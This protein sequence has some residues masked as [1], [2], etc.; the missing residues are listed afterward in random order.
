MNKNLTEETLK[1]FS[2]KN[3]ENIVNKLKHK[4]EEIGDESVISVV[5]KNNVTIDAIQEVQM[6]IDN[7]NTTNDLTRVYDFY[8]KCS[9]DNNKK[10]YLCNLIPLKNLIPSQEMVNDIL[11]LNFSNGA[12]LEIRLIKSV[13]NGC[14]S[15][16]QSPPFNFKD[17][18]N[19]ID[20]NNH[21][22]INKLYDQCPKEHIRKMYLGKL[23]TIKDFKPSNQ[24]VKDIANF[25]FDSEAP[26][27]IKLFKS[28][29][30]NSKL[31]SLDNCL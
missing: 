30:G 21:N 3:M 1:Y 2:D 7:Y 11:K 14:T 22:E 27:E 24:M 23:M 8:N 28:I 12:P 5:N 29:F 17:M 19:A 26:V 4:M 25:E 15:N 6:I 13:F 10:L 18:Q 31:L 16:D 20:N 9:D